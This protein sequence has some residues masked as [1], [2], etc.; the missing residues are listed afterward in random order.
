MKVNVVSEKENPVFNRKELVVGVDNM[1]GP[2]PKKSEVLDQLSA[3]INTD[4]ELIVVKSLIQSYGSGKGHAQVKVYKDVAAK[5]LA[6]PNVKKVEGEEAT[7][8][9]GETSTEA[10]AEPAA[11]EKPV[12]ESKPEEKPAEETP[13]EESKAEEKP[14]EEAKADKAPSE[15]SKAEE[16][17]A[18]EKK[19]ESAEEKVE[20]KA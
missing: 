5:E 4:K 17:P 10:P 13:K 1:G 18:E 19:E 8:E 2:T 9:G 12:E 16:K 20:G 11:E 3:Q 14:V 7:A 6:E 15:E